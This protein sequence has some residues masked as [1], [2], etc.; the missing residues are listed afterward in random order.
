MDSGIFAGQVRHVRHMPVVHSFSYSMFMMYLDLAELPTVF[1]GRWFWSATSPALARFRRSDHLGDPAVP[2]ATAV[3]SLVEERTGSRPVG[4]I[5]LLTHLRY[6]GYC[7]NPASFYYC[8][9]KTGSYVETIVV[10]VNNTPWGEQHCYVL[11]ASLS[12]QSGTTMRFRPGKEMHVSPFMPM[13]VDYDWQFTQPAE[14]LR[15]FM[16]NSLNGERVFD[17]SLLL[18]RREI[19]GVA[20]ARVLL[21]HPLMTVRLITAIYWQALKLWF[22]R[23]PLHIHPAKKNKATMQ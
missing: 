8:F 13:D 19:S 4:P 15:V 10:E 12:T 17:A 1:A 21:V 7:F 5:R 11:P 6:F 20:L 16:A 9:D 18:Q 23:V 3:A 22:K 14:V 2:L